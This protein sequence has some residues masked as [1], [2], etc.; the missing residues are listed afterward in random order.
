MEQLVKDQAT[1]VEH[2]PKYQEEQFPIDQEV[3]YK[4]E[5]QEEFSKD[6]EVE[7]KPEDQEE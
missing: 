7:C 5:D 6:Q 4:P 3:E 1:V 2:K